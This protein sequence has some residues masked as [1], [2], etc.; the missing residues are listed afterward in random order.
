MRLLLI[1]HG[2]TPN[3]V[4]GHLDTAFP[5]AGLSTLGKQQALAVPSA[6]ATQNITA[7]ITA[8]Y[9]SPLIRTQLTAE[10]LAATLGRDIRVVPGLEEISAG[11]L[12]M[13]NDPAS[14]EA[15][16]TCLIS[17][18]EGD[19]DQRMPGGTTGHEFIE[20]YDNTLRM[21]ARAHSPEDSVAVFSHGA[22]IRV[23]TA[24]STSMPPVRVRTLT[25]HNTG[26]SIL[27]GDPDQQWSL[28]AWQS[29]P[30]GGAALEGATS[31]DVTGNAG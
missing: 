25:L 30:L 27:N 3:N 6:L 16:A 19:L 5:G 2:Q 22:A 7:S 13:L 23:Y 14:V 10:P 15:Y 12:E 29:D 24:V 21:F 1:R 26:M 28:E 8:I 4:T 18:M 20:R 11:N 17:W 31:H 9:A